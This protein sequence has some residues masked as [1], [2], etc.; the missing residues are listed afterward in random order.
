[1]TLR[2]SRVLLTGLLLAGVAAAEE[3]S[4]LATV[5]ALQARIQDASAS[6]DERYD[7]YK[8][9]K[10]ALKNGDAACQAA[11]AAIRADVAVGLR[12]EEVPSS[13]WLMGLFGACLLWGGFSV[14]CI[15]AIRSG[16]GGTEAD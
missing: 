1:M 16:K 7:A 14:C 15:I 8:E 4:C 5:Q 9:A 2:S 11:Y 3:E 12:R 13:G 6:W 10:A